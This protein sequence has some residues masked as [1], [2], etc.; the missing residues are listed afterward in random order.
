MN[1]LTTCDENSFLLSSDPFK[2]DTLDVAIAMATSGVKLKLSLVPYP[3]SWC[4]APTTS[5]AMG[6]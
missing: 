1:F 3:C 6:R 2:V 5:P 4:K